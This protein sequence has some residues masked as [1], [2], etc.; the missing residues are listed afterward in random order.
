MGSVGRAGDSKLLLVS[1]AK[2][3][4]DQVLARPKAAYQELGAMFL[5]FREDTAS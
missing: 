3:H 4:R 2:Q 1:L 5:V